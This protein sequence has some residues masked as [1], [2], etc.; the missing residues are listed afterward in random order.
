MLGIA[1]F[2]DNPI[3]WCL[4]AIVSSSFSIALLYLLALRLTGNRTASLSV[5][6]LNV[7]RRTR[8]PRPGFDSPRGLMVLLA[9][10]P[11]YAI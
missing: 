8:R 4:P 6:A 9:R 7:I 11:I 10:Q 2:G 1:L 5:A 3:G